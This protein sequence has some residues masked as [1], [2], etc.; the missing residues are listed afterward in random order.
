MAGDMRG[1]PQ[2]FVWATSA[3]LKKQGDSLR[4]ERWWWICRTCWQEPARPSSS[5]IYIARYRGAGGSPSR[6]HD[7]ATRRP[8]LYVSETRAGQVKKRKAP[9]KRGQVQLRNVSL[10]QRP[11]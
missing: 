6:D 7:N 10:W 8:E 5:I 4:L 2:L 9:P 1:L 3:S 11:S